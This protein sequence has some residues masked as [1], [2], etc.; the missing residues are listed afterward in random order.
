MGK[1][2]KQV[3]IST[4]CQGITT[5]LLD[6]DGKSIRKVYADNRDRVWTKPVWDKKHRFYIDELVKVDSHYEDGKYVD[7]CQVHNRIYFTKKWV[8]IPGPEGGP[9]YQKR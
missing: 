2:V 5:F 7:S 3:F 1:S 4:Y 6:F 8:P 9:E